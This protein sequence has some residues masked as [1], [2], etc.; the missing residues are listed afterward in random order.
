MTS[1]PLTKGFYA[2]RRC[3]GLISTT[4]VQG[5]CRGC[6]CR[7]ILFVDELGEDDQPLR[8]RAYV[9]RRIAGD[10]GKPRIRSRP[11]YRH[12]V[13]LNDFLP[14]DFVP[15]SLAVALHQQGVT[16]LEFVE[17]A[18]ERITMTRDHRIARRASGVSLPYGH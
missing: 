14:N 7:L 15:E 5:A 10:Q 16:A 9:V 4:S 17:V 18:E 3:R 1:E 8:R 11:Q 12:V 6:A 13:G 2:C